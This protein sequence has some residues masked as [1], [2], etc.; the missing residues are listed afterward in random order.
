MTSPQSTVTGPVR[1]Q[2]DAL[3][4]GTDLVTVGIGGNDLSLFG[5]ISGV[6]RRLKRSD[7]EGG[8]CRRFF[9]HHGV[10]TKI[11]E[12]RAVGPRV[13]AVV[14]GVRQRA[15]HARILV[16]GYPRITRAGGVCR[17]HV[18]ADADSRWSDR[19]EQV[20]NASIRAAVRRQGGHFV[21]LYPSTRGH[22]ACAGARSWVN[23]PVNHPF[24]AAAFH[25]F[26]SGMLNDAV[27]AYRAAVG[28]RPTSR[29]VRTAR[30]TARQ[31]RA[32][33][34]LYAGPR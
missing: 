29:Q 14:A 27:Q 30:R 12:A 34:R 17:A 9:T 11:R 8:P 21:D 20:L 23:G 13:G 31:N 2:F 33:E 18:F 7:P 1:P 32:V 4:T 16:L 3:T 19:V 5:S 26:F 10:D 24:R 28:T 22:D 25:P 15:P 6:C